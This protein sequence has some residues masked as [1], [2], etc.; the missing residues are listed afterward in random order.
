MLS[1][2][3]YNNSRIGLNELLTDRDSLTYSLEYLALVNPA[4]YMSDPRYAAIIA[5]ARSQ[6]STDGFRV[7]IEGVVAGPSNGAMFLMSALAEP[8]M[9]L[10]MIRDAWTDF[11]YT[12]A[13]Q[14]LQLMQGNIFGAV[15]DFES[16]AT[17][18]G[19]GTGLSAVVGALVPSSRLVAGEG[20]IPWGRGIQ[21]Q[22]LPWEDILEPS[23][24]LGSR[25][26]EG[27]PTFDFFD[28][29]TGVAVSAKTLDTTTLAKYSNPSAVYSSIKGNID[30][31]ARFSKPAS[32]GDKTVDPKKIAAREVH[33]AVPTST[34]AA[35]W[36]QIKRAIDYGKQ[37]GV[38]VKVTPVK[39]G[40]G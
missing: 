11:T 23:M 39:G 10:D 27:F 22:G 3:E 40:G 36:V 34:T 16:T 19:V 18:T 8:G 32:K 6:G 33:L 26:P 20:K 5:E 25:L 14:T 12:G 2:N 21:A 30:S 37:Q 13:D 4:T 31:V 17:S 7:G 28:D 24:P 9:A 35:Q 29:V 38:T 15:Y 1:G